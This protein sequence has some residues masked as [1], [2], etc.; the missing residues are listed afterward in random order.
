MGVSQCDDGKAESTSTTGSGCA[1]ADGYLHTSRSSNP[2]PAGRCKRRSRLYTAS[3]CVA[4]DA[5]TK[6]FHRFSARSASSG[7][8]SNRVKCTRLGRV[9]LFVVAMI[10]SNWHVLLRCWGILL[11]NIASNG[12]IASAGVYTSA[13][14]KLSSRIENHGHA[15]VDLGGLGGGALMGN[16]ANIAIATQWFGF[17]SAVAACGRRCQGCW[18]VQPRGSIPGSLCSIC[19]P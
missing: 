5:S 15:L 18:G 4:D 6:A 17:A 11:G 16:V 19:D 14:L 10:A 8:V 3:R 12:R 13:Q 7:R 9:W 2:I 1:I